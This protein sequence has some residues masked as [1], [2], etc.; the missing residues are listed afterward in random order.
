MSSAAKHALARCLGESRG[1]CL[2]LSDI[3][4]V[5]LGI[6]WSPFRLASRP[7]ITR[8]H[9]CVPSLSLAAVAVLAAGLVALLAS[10]RS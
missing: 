7:Q 6:R 4:R 2:S 1:T 3:S 10:R 9:S 5:R 8:G